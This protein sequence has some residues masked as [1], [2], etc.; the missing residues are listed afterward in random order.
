MINFPEK[1]L[2]TVQRGSALVIFIFL[3]WLVISINSIEIQNY[4]DTLEWINRDY[5]SI[6]LF[7]LSV[8][9]LFHSNLGLSVIIDDYVHNPN[10]KKIFFI[11]KNS[12]T[13]ISMMFSGIC[14][15][16]I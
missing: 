1:L 6:L 7:I 14:L 2:W 13:L 10:Y 4:Y 12:F 9:I 16:L 5:N 11:A 15:Y 8:F 3:I